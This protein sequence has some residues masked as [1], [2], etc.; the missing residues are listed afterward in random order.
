M[1]ISAPKM[2]VKSHYPWP[3]KALFLALV[4]GFGG[5]IA[6]WIYDLGRDFTGHSPVV[7]KQQLADLNEKVGALTAERDRFSSTVNAAESRLNIEKAAQ[8]QLG[9]QIKVLETENAKLKEDL[10]FFEGLLPNATGSQGITIQR[11]T[12]ELLTPTQLRYRM[13]IMQGGK[14][15]NFV[16]NVQLLVTATVAGKSTVLTFPGASATA[17]EKTASQLDFKYYQRVEAE[18]TLPEGAVVKAIQAKVM[19]KGQMRAQ[20]TSNL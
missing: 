10:A 17:A 1:S 15:A 4:L 8:E 7:S 9:Q 16:G 13:L 2:T 11:L 3:L 5:A 19:E 18:L 14:G 12:A 6:L 20:Q